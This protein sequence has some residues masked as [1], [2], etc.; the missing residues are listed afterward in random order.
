MTT[1]TRP[2]PANPDDT[3]LSLARI[4]YASDS[5]DDVYA[6]ISR[7]AVDVI[8]GC[9]HAC[10][11]TLTAGQ[12]MVCQ[13]ASDEIARMIDGFES[14]CG[15]GPCVDTILE[16]RFQ[17]DSDIAASSSWPRLTALVLDRTPVRGMV[18][19]RVL[20]G[21]GKAGALNV[22]SDTPGA[23]TAQAAD[24]GTVLAAFASVALSASAERQR[25]DSLMAGL[26]SNREI[27]KAVGILMATHHIDDDQAFEVLRTMSSE[28]NVKLAQVA[29]RLVDRQ[30]K[31]SADRASLG[32][33]GD[34]RQ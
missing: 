25:A 11:S 26:H 29:A 9:D 22:F 27:G 15:E 19:Y 34:Q 10:V 8:P 14:E 13:G 18:S 31:S 5:Y 6:G 2:D 1:Q 33:G 3:F 28:L 24:V 21:D 32:E 30:K 20:V 4:V 7:A 12:K 17:L 16:Q 23:L